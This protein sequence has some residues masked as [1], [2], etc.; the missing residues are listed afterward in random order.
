MMKKFVALLLALCIA[1][2]VFA[3][4]NRT[5]PADDVNTVVETPIY[6]QEDSTAQDTAEGDGTVTAAT[7]QT[8][9]IDFA[10]LYATHE[11]DE[12]VAVVNGRDVTWQSYFYWLYTQA[13]QIQNYFTQ[14]T[15]YYAEVHTW[16]EVAYEES[17]TTFAQAT[18][19]NAAVM[20]RQLHGI[21]D[22]AAENGVEL[23]EADETAIAAQLE[24][25]IKSICGEEA[26]ED[27]FNAKIAGSYL[28][29]ELYDRINRIDKLYANG[30]TNKYGE[31]GS[32][33]DD[34]TAVKYL[35]DYGY[36]S[37]T[38]ILFMTIDP[39]TREALD[40]AAVA[41]KKAQAEKIAE[42]LAAITDP[43]ELTARFAEL[44]EEYDEDT[45]KTIY[46]DGYVFTEGTMVTEFEDA[47]KSL[48]AG[49]VSGV[50]ESSYGYHIIM[51]LAP[52]AERTVSY[53]S[54]GATAY[55][56]RYL[57]ASNAYAE[58]VEKFVDEIE[59]DFADGF[60]INLLNYVV[61]GE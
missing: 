41:E 17:G 7:T 52:D 37:A 1:F 2:A 9:S 38:H 44:K 30:F 6:A 15:A 40:E 45:G 21:E 16:N 4:C 18:V 51:R 42:E 43:A 27:E 47:V 29:R 22:F 14:M 46:P 58:E 8:E 13:I 12:V 59:I 49:E 60:E 26:T 35:E 10:A 50:V 33:V 5:D 3:G 61:K 32:K 57:Y 19:D 28:T 34:E 20:L 56:A 24:S 48:D 23:T 25:D 11:P 54:D 36:L 31:N 55:S 39:T 53:S